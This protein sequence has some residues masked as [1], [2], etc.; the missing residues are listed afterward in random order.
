MDIHYII[1]FTFEIM[2]MFL[3]HYSKMVGEKNL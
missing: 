1:F 2:H 3:N